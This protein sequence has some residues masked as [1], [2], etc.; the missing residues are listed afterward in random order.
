MNTIIEYRISLPNGKK[1]SGHITITEDVNTEH[2]A[3]KKSLKCLERK[4]TA[5]L[6]EIE[7]AKV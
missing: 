6:K 1:A 5:A 4:L 7:T 3:W 2:P